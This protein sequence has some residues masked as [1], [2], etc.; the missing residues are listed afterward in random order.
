MVS[1]ILVPTDGS[2]LAM[3][4]VHEALALAAA[5]GVPI[6]AYH[7]TA[8]FLYTYM[9]DYAIPNQG[10]AT[11]HK[12]ASKLY[13]AEVLAKVKELA[14]RANVTCST[15]T[16]ED[17]IVHEGVLAAAKRSGA[18]L[19][20][21]GSHGHGPIGQVFLGSV[22]MKIVSSSDLPVLIVRS[23]KV[24]SAG[25]TGAKKEDNLIRTVVGN[26]LQFFTRCPSVDFA[27][28]F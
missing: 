5:L 22:A 7:C 26:P 11:A 23:P 12:K 4:A 17:A 20:V 10:D 3:H 16:S 2:E 13:A 21:I 15:L 28:V 18:D 25:S 14:Q 6:V 8:P 24:K 27:Q 9:A 19:I 1:K